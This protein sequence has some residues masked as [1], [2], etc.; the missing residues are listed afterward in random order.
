MRRALQASPVLAAITIALALPGC[1]SGGSTTGAAAPAGGTPVVPAPPAPAKAATKQ[2]AAAAEAAAP[3]GAS[4]TLRAIY[5]QFPT[6]R[7]ES[8][9]PTAAKAVKAGAA[10]CRG[11]TPTAVKEEFYAEAEEELEPEQAKMIGQ[12]G[13]FEAQEKTDRSFVA[14]QLAADTYAATLPEEESQAGYQG[15]VYALA[16]GLEQRLAPEQ[17]DK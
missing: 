3:K 7:T 9:E 13:H 12:I 15:C 14:G 4:P 8:M 16:Q 11:K 5:R 17:E 10:A 1:G 2:A 6:P